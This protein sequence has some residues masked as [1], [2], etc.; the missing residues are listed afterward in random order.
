M[1]GVGEG[2]DVVAGGASVMVVDRI[3]RL[4]TGLVLGLPD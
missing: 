2:V 3:V 4:V 1:L